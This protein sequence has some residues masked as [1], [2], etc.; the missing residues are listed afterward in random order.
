MFAALSARE[1]RR[2]LLSIAAPVPSAAA[3]PDA[4]ADLDERLADLLRPEAFVPSPASLGPY[5]AAASRDADGEIAARRERAPAPPEG[6]EA[7]TAFEPDPDARRAHHRR[8]SRLEDSL[9]R[10]RD[11][12]RRARE[13]A[14]RAAGF[15]GTAALASAVARV[16]LAALAVSVERGAIEPLDAAVARAARDRGAAG[17]PSV[18]PA[19]ARLVAYDA[20]VPPREIPPLL[21]AV[22][23]GLG[24]AASLPELVPSGAPPA[25]ARAVLVPGSKG[26]VVSGT[27]G[28]A[29]GLRAALHAF[30]RGLRAGFLAGIADAERIASADP[31]F[32]A[33]AGALFRR[34]RWFPSPEGLAQARSFEDA[35]APRLAW[36]RLAAALDEGVDPA[37]AAERATGRP[38]YPDIASRA[39]D[40]YAA[41]VALRGEILAL[42]LE[43]RLRTRWGNAWLEHA[44]AGRFLGEVWEAGLQATPE[45]VAEDACAGT[46]APDP[47][48]EACR[49]F[50]RVS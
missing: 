15:D 33:A 37:R 13:R 4:P 10:P 32:D 30:G 36:A 41:A 21:R 16:D 20:I 23:G 9:L 31:V 49:P 50:R 8:W 5:L 42:A 44:G 34:A 46:M 3:L 45:A 40:P 18:S 47:I 38:A 28:G 22:A 48:L 26:I 11:E 2:L 12:R 6:W 43:E 1:A 14:S 39:D 29:G 27:R 17:D 35:V 7:A 19:L 24:L 25:F